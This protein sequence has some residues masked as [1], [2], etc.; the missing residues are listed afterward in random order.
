M[1]KI[2]RGLLEIIVEIIEF[3]ILVIAIGYV[4]FR[5]IL[6]DHYGFDSAKE[7]LDECFEICKRI[8]LRKIYWIK[9]GEYPTEEA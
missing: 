6:P 1:M 9:N 3:P 2:L 5:A 4:C 7:F 8:Y